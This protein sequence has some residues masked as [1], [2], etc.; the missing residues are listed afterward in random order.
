M[1]TITSSSK[2]MTP[3][4]KAHIL[5]SSLP[6]EGL[7]FE[8]SWR[9]S[10]DPLP[11]SKGLYQK[12]VDLGPRLHSFNKACNLLYRQSV[13]GKQPKWIHQYLDAGKPD[14]LL[15]TARHPHF[16]NDVIISSNLII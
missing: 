15:K 13:E 10:P 1:N 12:V 5:R 4:E 7:F 11:L 14:F 16:K 8:K 6:P 9:I 2:S 3:S